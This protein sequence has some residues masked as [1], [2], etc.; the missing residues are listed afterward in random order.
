MEHFPPGGQWRSLL[1]LAFCGVVSAHAQS[2]KDASFLSTLGELREAGY[3]DKAVIAERL[4]ETGHP[5]VRA[6][7]TALMEDRLYYRNG[8]Q[9]VFIGKSADADPIGLI[10]PL[11][12]KNSGSASADSLTKI[13]TNNG[14]RSK[15][16]TTVAH[17]SLSSPETSVRLDAVRE[18]S[19]SL[20][21]P[22]VSLLRARLDVETNSGVRKEIATGLALAALDGSDSKARLDAVDTLSHS[23]SQD[24]RNRVALL[25]DKSSDGSFAEKDENV[26]R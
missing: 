2:P 20:D 25:L 16:R 22:T 4:S 9:K 23:V 15:L 8:D 12:L 17:F 24:V 18:M 1:L 10:D 13:G 11:S 5:S 6:V 26:R 3:S 7:L 21:D 14:L 19:R